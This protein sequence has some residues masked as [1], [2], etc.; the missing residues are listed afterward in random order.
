MTPKHHYLCILSINNFGKQAG[1]QAGISSGGLVPTSVHFQILSLSLRENKS[2]IYSSI[3][4]CGGCCC[5]CLGQECRGF[6]SVGVAWPPSEPISSRPSVLPLLVKLRW[7]GGRSVLIKPAVVQNDQPA[8]VSFVLMSTV[9]LRFEIDWLDNW[10]KLGFLFYLITTVCLHW[11]KEEEDK[12]ECG[13]AF[14]L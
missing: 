9:C 2:I 10:L 14:D 3:P 5:C 13:R 1:R 7:N 4:I 6:N 11:K 12:G 8:F